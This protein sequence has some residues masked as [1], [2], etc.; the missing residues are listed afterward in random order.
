MKHFITTL[1]ALATI[2]FVAGV[3]LTS[4]NGKDIPAEKT[5]TNPAD[6]FPKKHD[7]ALL[8]VTFGSTFD[9]PAKTFEMQKSFFGS[10]FPNTDL[11]I[12]YTS[13]TIINRLQAQGKEFIPPA[14]WMESFRGKN[15]KNVY[16]QSLHVI[17]GEEF[18]LLDRAYVHKEYNVYLEDDRR[19]RNDA[20]LGRPLLYSQEDIKRVAKILV[21]DHKEAIKKGEVVAFMGHGNPE[22]L[23]RDANQR[24][25]DVEKEMREYAKKTYGHDYIYVATVDFPERLFDYLSGELQKIEKTIPAKTIHLQPLMTIVGDH[26]NNDMAGDYDK[27]AK[28]EEQSWKVQLEK[29]GW[30]VEA[31]MKGLGD[32]KEIN[33]IYLE[34]LKEAIAELK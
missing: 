22:A 4:C 2:T 9:V 32:Y 31:H 26:A 20:V 14:K 25:I 18:T 19:G 7:T 29:M 12:S 11:Y 34:H 16:V 24:Y 1:V 8:L 23:H 5:S 13:R 28:P 17:P 3:T 15:Y 30:K 10:A 33:Q 6:A 21:D 27:D